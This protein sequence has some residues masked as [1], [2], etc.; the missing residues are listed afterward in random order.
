MNTKL[1]EA[2]FVDLSD[3]ELKDAVGTIHEQLKRL[4]EAMK[5]DT[6]IAELKQR[7]RELEKTR[8]RTSIGLLA[9][10][11]RAARSLAS[12]RGIKFDVE[13][14]VPEVPNEEA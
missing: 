11:L 6:E 4:T 5:A 9:R 7:A 13:Q 2:G 8:Y 12:T 10:Q 1:L 3:A 14:F